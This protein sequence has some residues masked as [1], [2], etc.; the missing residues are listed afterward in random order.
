MNLFAILIYEFFKIGLFAIGGGYATLP[1]L[2]HLSS[3]YHW[4]STQDLIQMLAIANIVPGPVGLNLASQTGFKVAGFWGAMV[5]VIGIMIPSLI[6]VLL[7]SKL[8]KEFEGN[9]FV[10]AILYMLKPASCGMIAA[11]GFRLLKDAVLV[12]GQFIVINS[13][14]WSALILFL[15]LFGIS[16]KKKHSPLFYLGISALVGI[17]LTFLYKII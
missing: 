7:V 5:A 10:R 15:V 3:L 11:I 12:H 16:I 4:F 8:L 14:D 6:F 1:F 2:F 17:L 9:K 13:I